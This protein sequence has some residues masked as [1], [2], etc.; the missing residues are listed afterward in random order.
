MRTLL[1]IATI[2]FVVAGCVFVY[3]ENVKTRKSIEETKA[4]IEN[5]RKELKDHVRTFCY[6][7]FVTHSMLDTRFTKV[8]EQIRRIKVGA[9]MIAGR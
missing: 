9:E 3:N 2:V 8:E 5:V 6:E 4:T 1:N 7:R